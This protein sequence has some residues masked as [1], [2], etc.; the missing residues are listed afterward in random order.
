MSFMQP[1]N[2]AIDSSVLR[3]CVLLNGWN[4]WHCLNTILWVKP[5]NI[6]LILLYISACTPDSPEMNITW[7]Y[8]FDWI[9]RNRR[10]GLPIIHLWMLLFKNFCKY[11]FE[12]IIIHIFYY[13][14]LLFSFSIFPSP[15]LPSNPY[16][17]VTVPETHWRMMSD[18]LYIISHFSLDVC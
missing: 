14:L 6:S 16:L 10:W 12:Y 9:W 17:I 4:I 5:P 3:S 11:S 7:T 13:F 15:L 1:Q 8:I 18:R 2:I